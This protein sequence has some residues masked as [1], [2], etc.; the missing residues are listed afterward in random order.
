MYDDDN[1]YHNLGSGKRHTNAYNINRSKHPWSAQT[2]M[3]VHCWE[4]SGWPMQKWMLL[5]GPSV[6]SQCVGRHMRVSA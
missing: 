4:R 6:A 1:G 3:S 2:D 5:Q